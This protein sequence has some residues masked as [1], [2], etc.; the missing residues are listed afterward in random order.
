MVRV[1]DR[2]TVRGHP[3]VFRQDGGFDDV[4]CLVWVESA[5]T[6]VGVCSHG[7]HAP[8]TA[9]QLATVAEGLVRSP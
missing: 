3:A 8:L 9:A 4:R 2:L 1:L 6:G 7:V 5:T